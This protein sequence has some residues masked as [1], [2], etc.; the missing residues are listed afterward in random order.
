M[1]IGILLFPLQV[2]AINIGTTIFDIF[3]IFTVILNSVTIV[4]LLI[5]RD[6]K[7]SVRLMYTVLPV[8]FFIILYIFLHPQPIYRFLSAFFWLVSLLITFFLSKYYQSNYLWRNFLIISFISAFIILIQYFVLGVDRPGA[9][10]KEP[11]TA[12]LIM[13]SLAFYYFR[14]IIYHPKVRSNFF[15][16]FIFVTAGLLT[17]SSHI[18]VLVIFIIFT[19]LNNISF[20]KVTIIGSILIFTLLMALVSSYDLEY[21]TLKFNFSEDADFNISQLSWLRG[22]D[23]AINAVT[24][25]P[26]FGY[27]LGSTGYIYFYSI[28]TDPLE[29]YSLGDINL[30]DAY[31]LFLR[32]VIE[33]GAIST[34]LLLFYIFKPFKGAFNPKKYCDNRDKDFSKYYVIGIFIFFGSLIKEPNYGVSPLF[35]SILFIGIF[36]NYNLNREHELK[37]LN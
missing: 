25:S 15:Y 13:Y 7:L 16:F 5:K 20:R 28:Y 8:F 9:F 21:Y 10:F 34:I 3:P 30:Y 1:S 26:I 31:S 37:Q 19:L 11:S 32:L 12:G 2:I 29:K 22:L 6:F 18:V 27:G 33:L 14:N 35:L 4:F 24:R 23:Q 36:Y 17:K